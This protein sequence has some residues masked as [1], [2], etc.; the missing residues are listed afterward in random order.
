MTLLFQ[1]RRCFATIAVASSAF[2]VA[3]L[4][5]TRLINLEACPLCILQRMAYLLATLL[6]GIG[7]LVAARTGPRRAAALFTAVATA[8]GAFIAGYQVW[9]QRIAP[10]ISCGGRPTWWE[11]FVDWAGQQVPWLFAAGGQCA[12][13]AWSFLGLSLADWSAL[14]FIALTVLALAAAFAA[15]AHRPD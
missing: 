5:L 15:P 2:V 12:D 10:S 13:V 3:A 6:A 7:W 11:N 1:P 14:A 4:L 8:T 9:I